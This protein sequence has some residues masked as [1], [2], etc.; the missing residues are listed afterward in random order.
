MDRFSEFLADY[1]AGSSVEDLILFAQD[2][3]T[4]GFMR[5]NYGERENLKRY[6]TI[7]P[8]AIPL[9]DLKIPVALVS[10]SLDLLAEPTD[11]AW[12]AER[13]SSAVVFN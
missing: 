3:Q 10:G 4:E 6:G 7:E 2:V 1:P 9:E 12:L 13:I 11:V 8:P 5:F